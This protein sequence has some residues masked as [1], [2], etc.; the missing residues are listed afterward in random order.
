MVIAAMAEERFLIVTDPIAQ[1]WMSRKTGDPE[2]WLRGMRRL[3]V[4]LEKERS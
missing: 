2:R 1:E 3:Q 4:E